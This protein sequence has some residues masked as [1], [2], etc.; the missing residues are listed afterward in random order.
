MKNQVPQH[1]VCIYTVS[2]VYA[3][4]PLHHCVTEV[5]FGETNPPL[6]PAGPGPA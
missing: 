3:F 4:L 6:P 1:C 5:W 2:S